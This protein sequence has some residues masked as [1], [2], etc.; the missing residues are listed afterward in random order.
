MAETRV[1]WV[2]IGVMGKSMCGHLLKA[3]HTLVVFDIAEAHKFDEMPEGWQHW[4]VIACVKRGFHPHIVHV[5]WITSAHGKFTAGNPNHCIRRSAGR[6]GTV[7]L[8]GFKTAQSGKRFG[9]CSVNRGGSREAS[10]IGICTDAV[11]PAAA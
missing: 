9:V 1:G 8:R 5:W 7:Y 11:L 2:G 3:G 6:R 10:C 4:S